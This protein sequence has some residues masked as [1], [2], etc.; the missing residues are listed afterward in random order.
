MVSHVSGD[1]LRFK[2]WIT[3]SWM[4]SGDVSQSRAR[5]AARAFMQSLLENV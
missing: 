2:F 3:G 5:V 1:A 4:W